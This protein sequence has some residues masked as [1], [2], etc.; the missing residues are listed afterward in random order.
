MNQ[1]FTMPD[2][3]FETSWEVCNKVGGI[4]TVIATKSLYLGNSFKKNHHIHIGPDVWRDV[5]QNPEFSEDP[6]L[7][8]SWRQA[9][10]EEGLRL[11]IGH[12]NVP[13]EPV[14]ILV[15]FTTFISHK[16]EILTEL[17]K[18]FGVDSISGG[19]DYVESALFGYAAGKVIESFVRY[20]VKPHDKVVAQFHEWMTG[21]GLLYVKMSN[22]PIGTI[23][24]THATVIGRCVAG[25]NIPL[26]DGL[27]GLDAD[28]LSHEYGVVARH[29]L[30]KASAVASDVFTTVSEITAL[31]CK[32]FLGR[33]CDVI[34]PNGFENSITPAA[35]DY[36]DCRKAARRKL[37]EVASAM[38]GEAYPEDS[39]L[40][41]ISGR[42]EYSNKGIDVFLEAMSRLGRDPRL[43]KDILAFV[44]VPGCEMPH[45]D[46]GKVKVIFVPYYLTGN[47][48]MLNMTYYDLVLGNDLC[49]YPSYYEPWGYTPLEAIAFKVPCITTDLAGFGLWAQGEGVDN[50]EQGVRVIHRTDYNYEQVADEIKD[51]VMLFASFDENK[52][53]NARQQAAKLSKKALWKHFIRQYEKAYDL[54]L[55]KAE[56]RMA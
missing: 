33:D 40:V 3:L 23:F 52:V 1:N 54:A 27:A 18:R 19:W 46:E 5:A 38:G 7:F 42:Y 32:Q 36:D 14:A 17:W 24:T 9:A 15:D 31:E 41:A 44:M 2:Y 30:E 49:I 13:G 22:L 37:L 35:E 26:Y 55:R 8:R 28:R 47:D 10:A 21:A 43:E 45:R 12:W 56:A 6:A 51:T 16:D 29:S 25:K 50:I 34:T 48:G 39:L 53:K 11:R 4:H 20:N